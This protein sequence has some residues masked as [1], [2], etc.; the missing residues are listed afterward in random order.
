MEGW[1]LSI[2]GASNKWVRIQVGSDLRNWEYDYSAGYWVW[3]GPE[4]V[5]QLTVENS[6]DKVRF[7]RVLV[8]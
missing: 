3:M 8:E 5:K 1:R 7:Y 4:G 2:T 6:G